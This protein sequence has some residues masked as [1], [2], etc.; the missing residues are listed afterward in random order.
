MYRDMETPHALKKSVRRKDGVTLSLS[1]SGPVSEFREFLCRILGCSKPKRAR[2]DFSIGLPQNKP[3]VINPM[4]EVKIT[5]EQQVR[6]TLTPKTDTNKPAQ[7]D[8]V[9]TWTVVSGSSLVTAAE[10]GR[11]ALLVSSDTPGDTEI[12]VEADADLGEGVETISDI[13]KL[14]VA[15]ATAKNLG[16]A[17]GQPEAKPEAAPEPP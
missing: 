6:V 2:F 13:I 16:I 11:S 8:G 10:D 9:P 4:I 15:G 14:V 12:L 17:V 7:L 3:E 1:F 5:N